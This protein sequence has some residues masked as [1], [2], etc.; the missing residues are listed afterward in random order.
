MIMSH[1][2]VTGKVSQLKVHHLI[3]CCRLNRHMDKGAQ[4]CRWV[5]IT[6]LMPY[7]LCTMYDTGLELCSVF[8]QNGH[9]Y[10]KF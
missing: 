6:I 8:V 10:N 9:T 1:K 2:R 7:H 4:H 5:E 3:L